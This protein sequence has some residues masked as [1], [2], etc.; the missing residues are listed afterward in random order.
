MRICKEKDISSK[1]AW[2]AS[3]LRLLTYLFYL[4]DSRVYKKKKKLSSSHAL[5]KRINSYIFVAESR[6]ERYNKRARRSFA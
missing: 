4:L 5:E 1:F 3:K 2:F 6:V